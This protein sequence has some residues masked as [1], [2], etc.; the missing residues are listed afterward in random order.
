MEPEY[1]IKIFGFPFTVFLSAVFFV[2]I[3]ALI[4][5]FLIKEGKKHFNQN[6]NNKNLG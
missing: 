5:F 1:T 2:I 3:A 6:D 4:I